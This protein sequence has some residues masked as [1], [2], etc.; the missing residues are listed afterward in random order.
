MTRIVSRIQRSSAAIPRTLPAITVVLLLAALHGVLWYWCNQSEGVWTQA[1]ATDQAHDLTTAWIL[2]GA[3]GR[4]DLAA[5]VQGWMHASPV[6][7]PFVP[8]TSALLMLAGGESRIVA[9]AA[10]PLFTVVWLIATYAIVRRLYGLST[11]LWT[12]ALVSTFPVFLIYS[13]TYFFEHPLAAVFTCACWA[14]LA[15]DGFLRPL[16]SA[17][18]G[19]LAGVT[20]LTRGGAPVYLAGPLVVTLWGIRPAPDRRARLRRCVWALI[21]A[22]SIAATWYVPNAIALASYIYRATYGEDAVSRV[23]SASALSLSN[24][25]YYVTWIVA[26]GPGVPMLATIVTGIFA[27]WIVARRMDQPSRTTLALAAVF[28]IDFLLLLVAA[29]HEAARYF[30]PLTALVAL[31]IVRSIQTISM[32]AIRIS[33]AIATV[34]FAVHHLFALT[35]PAHPLSSVRTPYIRSLPFWDH[36]PYFVSLTNYYGIHPVSQDF[37]IRDAVD[38]LE[39]R[40]LRPGAVVATLQ[41]PHPFFQPNGLQLESI[42]R[43]V[44]LRF[45]WVPFVEE[46][47]YATVSRA[48]AALSID[49]V[50]LRTGGTS[51]SMESMMRGF[52]ALFDTAHG[53]FKRAGALTLGDGSSVSLYVRDVPQVQW[54]HAPVAQLDRA[55]AF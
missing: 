22:S 34:A 10:L 12:T 3:V 25:G 38:L 1:P 51:V 21:G 39:T 14:L 8:L 49:A 20:C 26:Q 36:E 13:R 54:T 32:R 23:G 46:D 18:F 15:T 9:E 42:R 37:R 53:T 5:F 27:G 40:R 4:H 35:L 30:Q 47:N 43:G 48:L 19:V 28:V 31:A 41:A 17:V 44:D 29:Q 6:H 55:S 7:T 45:V 33:V 2:F 16:P 11:A 24:A 52:P 50:L